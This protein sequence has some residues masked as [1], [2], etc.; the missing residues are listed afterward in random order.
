MLKVMAR[1]YSFDA[2][3]GLGTLKLTQ[4][5]NKWWI[6]KKLRSSDTLQRILTLITQH[7]SV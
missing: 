2:I 3:N 4:K 7:T 1:L 6:R 5:L